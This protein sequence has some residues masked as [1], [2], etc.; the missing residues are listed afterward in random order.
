[1]WGI[2]ILC[3]SHITHTFYV[4]ISMCLSKLKPTSFYLLFSMYECVFLLSSLVFQRWILLFILIQHFAFIYFFPLCIMTF[5][6]LYI[7][8]SVLLFSRSL[9][10]R[11][12]L[13]CG[14]FTSFSFPLFSYLVWH[15]HVVQYLFFI[16]Y[17]FFFFLV[18]FISILCECS[19]TKSRK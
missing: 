7:S 16:R 4:Y 2:R 8:Y 14:R 9:C 18:L 1:M 11:A 10:G 15:L 3:A 13:K 12:R 5:Y 17:S 6:P 19:N